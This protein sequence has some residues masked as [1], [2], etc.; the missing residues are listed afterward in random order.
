MAALPDT[1]S[2]ANGTG[3]DRQPVHSN[4]ATA[5]SVAAPVFRQAQPNQTTTFHGFFGGN[6][7]FEP[8]D[9]KLLIDNSN[10]NENETKMEIHDIHTTINAPVQRQAEP[11]PTCPA[12]SAMIKTGS[13]YLITPGD[14]ISA[15]LIAAHNAAN[16]AH[17][18]ANAARTCAVS[19]TT[20]AVAS[21][22]SCAT[23]AVASLL[24]PSYPPRSGF[25]PAEKGNGLRLPQ[26]FLPRCP[27]LGMGVV[28]GI[29]LIAYS[30]SGAKE[31][32]RFAQTSN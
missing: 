16:A 9:V 2:S 32:E 27:I 14:R 23:V 15:G 13:N 4:Q 29:A 6:N 31:S 18:A 3:T 30:Y 7:L 12:K 26:R 17:N 25:V 8:F 24:A 19:G 11:V 20:V 22:V 5:G 28:G 1:I 10:P 21:L